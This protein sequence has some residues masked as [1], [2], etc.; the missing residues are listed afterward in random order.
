MF[1]LIV[2]PYHQSEYQH[3]NYDTKYKGNSDAVNKRQRWPYYPEAERRYCRS[4]CSS[5]G[6]TQGD[7]A[8]DLQI[9]AL[10]LDSFRL[11]LCGDALRA[12]DPSEVRPTFP[13]SC[14]RL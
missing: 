12:I 4:D 2:S 9:R 10:H 13:L 1:H 5:K 3:T 8:F 14:S 6:T 11:E 7:L